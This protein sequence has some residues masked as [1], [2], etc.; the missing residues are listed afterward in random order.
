MDIRQEEETLFKV[1]AGSDAVSLAAAMSATLRD[2]HEITARAI[3]VGAVNQAA[4][5]VAIARGQVASS[6]RD[7][8]TRIGFETVT[9]TS[10]DQISAL[11]FRCTAQ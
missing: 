9:G 5:A 2:T 4:K 6:G 11:V 1:G 8:V 3:G 7:L 10:G